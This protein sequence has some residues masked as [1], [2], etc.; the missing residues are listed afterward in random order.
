MSSATAS[1]LL[2]R[3]LVAGAKALGLSEDDL[4][5]ATNE[6]SGVFESAAL[7]DPDGRVP[8]SLLLELWQL[9][10]TRCGDESFGFWLA[11]RLQAPPLSLASW[12]ITSSPT[13]GEGLERSLRFQRLLHDEAR[14]E[15][16]IGATEA[17]YRHQ[18][19]APP[20]RAPSAAI[21]FGFL[22]FLQL[23]QRITGSKIVPLRVQLRHGAPHDISRHRAWFGESLS[24][25]ADNDELVLDRASLD[26]PLVGA[27][28]TLSRIVEAHATAALSKLPVSA[29]LAARVRAHISEL[30]PRGATSVEVVCERLRLS[31]RT[32]Q[33]Q[34]NAQGTSFAKE[35]D[36][37]RHELAMRYLADPGIS[38][39]EATF[40]LGFSEASAFHRAFT[41]WTGQTPNQWRA[42]TMKLARTVR[43]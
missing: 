16:E 25:D 33:R 19:S 29:H 3:A 38:L 8:A 21:E 17:A 2:L 23:A 24:F 28:P 32:L 42:G 20:F 5:Q 36:R 31:R 43:R 27:D 7:A 39:Q 15:L 40:L 14:S 30:L 34:L 9:L 10:P 1:V 26:Q 37:T 12:V 35:L 4:S 41:R 11:E 6:P 13:L 18:V 22:S